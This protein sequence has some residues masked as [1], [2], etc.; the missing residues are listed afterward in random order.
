[1]KLNGKLATVLLCSTLCLSLAAAAPKGHRFQR[2]AQ[3]WGSA[4]HP[5]RLW[6]HELGQLRLHHRTAQKRHFREA[7]LH[8]DQQ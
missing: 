6:R 1:M 4:T 5:Q 3:E 8:L 2:T 7:A